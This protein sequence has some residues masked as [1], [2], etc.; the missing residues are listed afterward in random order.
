MNSQQSQRAILEMLA[1]NEEIIGQLYTGYADRFPEIRK[2][3][4]DLADDEKTHAMW[5]RTIKDMIIHGK[6]SLRSDRFDI[7]DISTFS[8]RIANEIAKTTGIGLNL[9]EALLQAISIEENLIEGKYFEAIETD[10]PDLKHML[11][12]LDT[13]TFEHA[14]KLREAWDIQ[15]LNIS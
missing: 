12:D 11:K 14:Q 13:A 9:K 5:I 7:S 4:L 15:R 6:L 10:S 2:F 3:W 1:K 8:N